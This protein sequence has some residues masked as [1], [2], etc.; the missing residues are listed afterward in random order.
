ML[1]WST[2]EFYLVVCTQKERKK[3]GVMYINL[4]RC[5]TA[6][7]KCHVLMYRPTPRFLGNFYIF[8]FNSAV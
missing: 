5:L 7:I 3:A 2:M 8:I 4:S 1:L 6:V